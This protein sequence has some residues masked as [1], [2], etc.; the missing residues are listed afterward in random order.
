MAQ[1]GKKIDDRTRAMIVAALTAG[2]C[3]ADVARAFDI[4]ETSVRR[5]RD[6]EVDM[7]E[8]VAEKRAVVAQT[9]DDYLEQERDRAQGFISKA[10]DYLSSEE[11]LAAATL[12]Q[13][14]TAM[15]IV[16]DKW[17]KVQAM[18][19]GNDSGVVILAPVKEDEESGVI[20]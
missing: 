18:S 14:A 3:V 11:K 4:S 19:E 9:M 7:A 13:I 17:G 2:E 12:S 1:Q 10:L 15:G 6:K 16:I 20:M 5:I 8:L